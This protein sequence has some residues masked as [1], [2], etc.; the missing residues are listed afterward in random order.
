M[1]IRMQKIYDSDN[2]I[3]RNIKQGFNYFMEVVDKCET[4]EEQYELLE[5]Y[6]KE[7]VSVYKDIDH[8]IYYKG[9]YWNDESYVSDD[10]HLWEIGR[11]IND[12]KFYLWRLECEYFASIEEEI[13][14][15]I[16]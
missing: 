1:K 5:M 7:Y 11:C 10:I 4:P 9:F 2:E 8:E 13:G 12:I 15:E 16:V 6:L 3:S 14:N